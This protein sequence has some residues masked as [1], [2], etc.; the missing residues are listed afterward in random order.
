MASLLTAGATKDE[1]DRGDYRSQ[2]WIRCEASVR[3]FEAVHS[4]ERHSAWWSLALW[5]AQ[6]DEEAVAARLAAEKEAKKAAKP[7]KAKKSDRRTNEGKTKEPDSGVPPSDA[8]R[9][10]CDGASERTKA[11][12]NTSKPCSRSSTKRVKRRGVVDEAPKR[13]ANPNHTTLRLPGI[14]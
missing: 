1:I 6:R 7:K 10:S 2:T 9:L 8:E 12:G 5:L 4:C 14:D 13:A 3:T 11:L